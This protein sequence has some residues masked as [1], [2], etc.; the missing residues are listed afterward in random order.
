LQARVAF[1]NIAQYHSPGSF[2]DWKALRLLPSCR[3]TLESAHGVLFSDARRGERIVVC[4]RSAKQWGLH[5]GT[6]EGHMFVPETTRQA[7]MR[8]GSM[9]E[10]IIVV[11]RKAISAGARR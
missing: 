9:R 6:K 2:K 3:V 4:L 10:E 7:H 5:R 11:V 8:H 1:L